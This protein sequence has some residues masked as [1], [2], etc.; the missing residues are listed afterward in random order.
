MLPHCFLS[1]GDFYILLP[2][3]VNPESMN[4]P[5]R[6]LIVD[7]EPETRELL[8][9]LIRS[10][11]GCELCGL[12]GNMDEAVDLTKA[13]VPD[14]VLLETK[15]SDKDAFRFLEYIRGQDRQPGLVLVSASDN[16]VIKSI[17]QLVLDYIRRSVRNEELHNALE[18]FP[19]SVNGKTSADLGRLAELLRKP[20]AVK[21]KFNTR[22]GYVLINPEEVVY[23]EADGNYTHILLAN[24]NSELTT[25]NLGA[26][27][28]LL[29]GQDFFRAGRSY[30]LNL[31]FLSRVDR[32]NNSCTLQY[33]MESVALKIPSQKIRL[34]EANFS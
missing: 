23:C 33:Q 25:Q 11:E 26:V 22:S 6:V 31:R 34:L 24:G 29:E 18:H 16:E 12:A 2:E 8:A 15:M 3:G 10:V 19:Y 13:L 9:F 14:L 4:V 21:K 30:L 17:H 5:L 27:E 1:S 32:K 20:A 28:L 7:D